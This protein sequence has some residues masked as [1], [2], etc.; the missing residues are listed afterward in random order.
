M[1]KLT[2]AKTILILLD[3]TDKHLYLEM[4]EFINTLVS[5]DEYIIFIVSTESSNPLYQSIKMGDFTE[6]EVNEIATIEDVDINRNECDTIIK[7]SGGLPSIIQLFIKQLKKT[8]NMSETREIE[9][10]IKN[11]S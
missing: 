3:N 10:Y 9:S 11:M 6:T 5:I 1:H 7:N 4:E 2:Q 8:G